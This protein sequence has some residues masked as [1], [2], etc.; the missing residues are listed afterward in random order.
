M[1]FWCAIVVLAYL[2][3][4]WAVANNDYFEKLGVAFLKPVFLLGANA[5]LLY[6]PLSGKDLI[7]K[8]YNSD[9]VKNEKC[10]LLILK[11]KK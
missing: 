6:K 8:W 5:N 7:N 10:E 11:N 1:F 4:K 9:E 2:F 3:Y